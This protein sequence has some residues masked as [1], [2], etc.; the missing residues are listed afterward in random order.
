MQNSVGFGRYK[1][2]QTS[3]VVNLPKPC[4]HLA[5]ALGANFVTYFI[6]MTFALIKQSK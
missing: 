4:T 2:R 6:C 1:N 5:Q 3:L